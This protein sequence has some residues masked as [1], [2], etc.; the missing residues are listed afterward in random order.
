MSH[1]NNLSLGFQVA[2]E[3]DGDSVT[4][5]F[6]VPVFNGL[7]PSPFRLPLRL[8]PTW[9]AYMWPT[10]GPMVLELN[11]LIGPPMGL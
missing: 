5:S 8:P 1:E 11:W 6:R 7:P 9:L 10:H 2:P 4:G 3:H